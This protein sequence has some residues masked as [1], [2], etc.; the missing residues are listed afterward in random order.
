MRIWFD[1]PA[2]DD[3]KRGW[4][5]DSARGMG[6]E[7]K[8]FPIGNGYLGA[9]IFGLTERERIHLSENSISTSGTTRNSG[10]TSFGEC[11]LEFNHSS[12]K[13]S[14]YKRELSLDEALA[15]VSYD[16]EGVRYE[17]EYFASYPDKVLV[18]KLSASK[19]KS[20]SFTLDMKIPYF[21]F[22]GRSGESFAKADND[23]RG[24]I[25]KL[26]GHLPGGNVDE[27]TAGYGKGT[28]GYEMDFEALAKVIVCGGEVKPIYKADGKYDE[29]L[30]EYSDAALSVSGSDAAYVIIALGTNYELC[31]QVFLE[32][33]NSKKL[34]GLPHPDKRLTEWIKSASEKSYD[35]LR[36]AHIADF[37][38][39]FSRVKINL[40][41]GGY[42]GT[43]EE[44][45]GRYKKGERIAYLE[46]LI[47][48]F[49]RYML[50]SSSR[51]GCLPPNLNGIW[52]RYH[53][54]ICLNGYWS[55]VNVQMNFWSAFNTNLAE[56]FKSY[57]GFYNAYLPANSKSAADVLIKKGRCSD[58]EKIEGTL[59]SIET[60]MTPFNAVSAGG[61]RDG[62]GNTPYMAESFFDYY[63]YTRDEKILSEVTLPALISSA[64]FLTRL[65]R[66]DEKKGIYLTD[67]SGS[68]EQSTTE[69]YLEYLKANPDFKPCGSTYDQGLAYSNYLHVLDALKVIDEGSL[70]DSDRAVIKRIREQINKLDPIPVGYSGQVKEFREEKF[71]G[72]IGEPEHRHISH[73]ATLHPASLINEADSPAWLDAA[74]VTM[75]NRGTHT[76]VWARVLRIIGFARLLDEERA[77]E[78]LASTL[79]EVVA[80]NLSSMFWGM[81]QIEGN[82]GLPSAIC[83]MLLQSH[84]GYIEPLAALPSVWKSGSYSGLVARGAFE[85]AAS[86]E[87]GFAKKITVKSKKGGVCRLK[88]I[89]ASKASVTDE[90]G[91]AVLKKDEGIDLISFMTKAGESY[92]VIPCGE[93]EKIE[94]PEKLKVSRDKKILKLD[95]SSVE[96]AECYNLYFAENSSPVYKIL[97]KAVKENAYVIKSEHSSKN[98]YTYA[99]SAVSKSGRESQRKTVTIPPFMAIKDALKIK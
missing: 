40:S 22:E 48:Q 4:R 62:W 9:R 57:V 80:D 67:N 14:G 77:Y 89:N 53:T 46:E 37:S 24:G 63:D 26:S 71:Y 52:N 54:A 88:Y 91:N 55:N 95:W 27:M 92:T 38:S 36:S 94:A 58:E 60:G 81:F 51:E 20:V 44:L 23:A 68:P 12:D 79:K 83:E 10:N 61:G 28:V 41:E 7:A 18:I 1:T 59:W 19:E 17:R 47:F 45:V 35:E 90:K 97:A 93:K 72:E 69:P 85:I 21:K 3:D 39:L 32:K 64:N 70:S 33:D 66:Y 56:C 2:P 87:N 49:G 8:A 84:A 96:N 29:E 30:D 73:L 6:W 11:Y 34:A 86:W 75:Q 74:R 5:Y 31:P 65:M 16:Y 50:I 82:L 13:I 43:T 25:L 99:V 76:S 42:N 15:K 78:F 98:L